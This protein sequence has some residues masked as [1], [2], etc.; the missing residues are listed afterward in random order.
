[1]ARGGAPLFQR[2]G[3]SNQA[4]A[5][6]RIASFPSTK[7]V[8]ASENLTAYKLPA[9]QVT[10][11]DQYGSLRYDT[12]HYSS[13]PPVVFTSRSM[14]RDDIMGSFYRNPTLDGDLHERKQ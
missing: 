6:K 7:P 3:S 8:L 2:S 13:I 5:R 12:A 11:L 14:F 1:M 10:R 9:T 4:R